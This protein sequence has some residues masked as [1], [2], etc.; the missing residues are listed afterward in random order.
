MFQ[1]LFVSVANASEVAGNAA[2]SPSL[3]QSMTPLIV[4]MAI[5]YFFIIRPQSKKYKEHQSLVDSTK[6]GDEVVILNGVFGK[7]SS[8]EEDS[9]LV[10][11][12]NGVSI[13]VYKSTILKNI[14]LVE[15]LKAEGVKNLT[16]DKK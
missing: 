6:I 5:F 11:V 12:A 4:I 8:V 9:C 15:R 16:K 10:E 7:L 3:V 2:Q 1:N 13:K 14:S